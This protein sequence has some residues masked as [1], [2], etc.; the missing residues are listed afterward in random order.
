MTDLVRAFYNCDVV[1]I[2]SGGVRIDQLIPP[3]PIKFSMISNIFDDFLVVKLVPGSILLQML[4][5]SCSK[6]PA[7]E[8]RFLLVSGIRYAFDANLQP[9]SRVLPGSVYINNKP[10]DLK[11]EYKVAMHSFTAKGG[12]G[13][14]VV[15]DCKYS[16]TA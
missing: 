1:T 13:F 2:N 15:K 5:N 16:I 7:F 4:E 3:G 8:G 11:R 14:D 12:D 6:Y 9:W 10:L